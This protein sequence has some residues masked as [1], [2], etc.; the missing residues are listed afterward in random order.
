M[1]DIVQRAGKAAHSIAAAHEI[2]LDQ[3]IVYGSYA[4][5]EAGKRSDIDLVLVSPDW[6]DVD[7]YA[8]PEAFLLDWPRDE[9]LTPDIIPLTPEEFAR[10][11]Q[12]ETDIVQ[13]AA[14]TGIVAEG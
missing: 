12:S 8:R 1:T 11:S 7:Y 5:G 10:R 13:T 3:I 9:L 2:R 4:R 6:E 14:E